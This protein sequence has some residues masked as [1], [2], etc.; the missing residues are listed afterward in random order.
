MTKKSVTVVVFMWGLDRIIE[1]PMQST[2][3]WMSDPRW[4]FENL[5]VFFF[6]FPS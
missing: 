4:G 6:F 2:R 5:G 1:N 3:V